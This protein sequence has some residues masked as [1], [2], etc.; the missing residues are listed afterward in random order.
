MKSKIDRVRALRTMREF[1]VAVRNDTEAGAMGRKAT[2][3][4]RMT[5]H[6]GRP[7]KHQRPRSPRVDPVDQVRWR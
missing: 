1:E 7:L 5:T 3:L 2:V 6:L 4:C